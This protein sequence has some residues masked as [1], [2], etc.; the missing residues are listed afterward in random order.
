MSNVL[1]TIVQ[2][3]LTWGNNKYIYIENAET[4]KLELVTERCHN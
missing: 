4:Y 3:V 1:H 2:T